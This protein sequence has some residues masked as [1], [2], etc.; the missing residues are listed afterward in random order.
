MTAEYILSHTDH[1][2]LAASATWPDIRRT[3][4]EAL[5]Y[6]TASACIPSAYVRR[7]HSE[8][9]DLTLCTVAGFPL[10]NANLAA[11]EAEVRQAL[12]DGA[13]EIDMVLSISAL[14]NGETAAVTA[15]IRAIKAFVGGQILKVIIEACYL[16]REEKIAACRCCTEGG[17]DYIKTSTGF[18]PGGA[19]LEDI[20]L[21][22]EHIGP[23]MKI[24]AAGGIRTR[25]AMESFLQAGCSRLGA[26]GAVAL[27]A[28]EMDER[29]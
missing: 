10:G 6:R 7:A 14:K 24:K 3:C 17:A 20:H 12:S 5:R 25:E 29:P 11:K 1:T 2:L 9:P 19:T 16:T 22:R 26:S 18:G 21:I 13:S 4:G 15:E 27:L 23:G 28:P 8:F